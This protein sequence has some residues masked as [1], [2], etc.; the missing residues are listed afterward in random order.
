MCVCFVYWE[1]Q[2]GDVTLCQFRD[3]LLMATS[4]PNHPTV[5]IVQRVLTILQL[6]W[7][8]RVLC[9]CDDTCRVTCLSTSAV[10]MGYF[11]VVSTEGCAST[12]IQPSSLTPQWDLKLGPPLV[13]PRS[14]HPRYLHGIFTGLLSNSQPWAKSHLAQLLTVAAWCQ[15]VVLC[16]YTQR[17][18]KRA[19]H[20]AI[21]H[22]YATLD[23]DYTRTV[24]YMHQV[25]LRVPQ[26]RCCNLHRAL[27]WV[28]RH[29]I[30]AHHS[31]ASWRLPPRIRR[32]YN[33]RLV[34]GPHH[35]LPTLG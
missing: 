7:G 6:A 13:S 16:G 21:V 1:T 14:A 9:P 5:G 3:N 28:K 19:M 12:Y 18:T 8:L 23:H 33:G 27:Q 26:P 10:A 32:W 24:A 29:G 25:V 35:P 31:Y 34:Q 2:W 17:D 15:V 20:S 30:W 22:S 11:L 4:F